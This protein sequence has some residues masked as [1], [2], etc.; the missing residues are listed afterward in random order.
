M[1]LE[2]ITLLYPYALLILP[3]YLLCQKLCG[4][5][6]PKILFSNFEVL[7]KIVSKKFYFLKILKYITILLISI[8]L[9]SPVIKHYIKVDNTKGYNISLLLDA[10]DSMQEDNRFEISK[11]ILKEFINKRK[12]DSIALTVFGDYA[13]VASPFTTNKNSLNTIIS[14]LNTGVAGDRS[15]A[16]YEALYLGSN[17]FKKTKAKKRVVIL[18]TDGINTVNSVSLKDTLNKIKDEKLKVYTISIGIDGDFN[19]KVLS[20][21]AKISGGK[22]YAIN[23]PSQLQEIYNQI[24]SLE[25]SNIENTQEIYYEYLFIYPTLLA[26]IL[27]IIYTILSSKKALILNVTITILLVTALLKPSINSQTKTPKNGIKF[28]ILLD[29]GNSML[30]KD[31]YPNRLKFA[32]HKIKT[33][34]RNLTSEKVSII[35]F[36]TQAYLIAPFSNNYKNLI[37]QI[38]HIDPSLTKQDNSNLLLALK[39]VSNFYS[40]DELKNILLLSDA[41]NLTNTKEA[42]KFAKTNNIKLYSYI[43]STKNGTIVFKNGN[44]I[45]DKN[46]NIKLFKSDKKTIKELKKIGIVK[47]FSLKDG[48]LNEFLQQIDNSKI[49]YIKSAKSQELFYIPLILSIV[50]IFYFDLKRRKFW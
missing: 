18:L 36:N 47:N 24:N 12:N 34:I 40:K 50:I 29:I 3:I 31:I 9:S 46:L 45:R 20:K 27:M 28:T 11:K 48:D 30:A 37:Y 10:S 49:K 23:K 2:N 44:V 35:A 21:I 8:A 17:I 22:S 39:G 13:F 7:E 43:I 38:E 19:K 6:A 41:S 16:L 26:L 4:T 14:Y 33:F 42:I 15:T 25:K 5:K 32:K 1:Q